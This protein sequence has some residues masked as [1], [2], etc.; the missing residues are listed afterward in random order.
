M[1]EAQIKTSKKQKIRNFL[2]N[3][4]MFLKCLPWTPGGDSKNKNLMEM[5]KK[6]EKQR[7]CAAL[8]VHSLLLRNSAMHGVKPSD[9][10]P[11]QSLPGGPGGPGRPGG[12]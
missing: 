8:P 7:A 6:R 5:D 1:P 2:P 11:G 9:P 10:D 3:L 12:Q 4:L